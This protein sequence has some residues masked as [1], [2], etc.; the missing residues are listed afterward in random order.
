MRSGDF[1]P[2]LKEWMRQ[3]G[4]GS[5]SKFASWFMGIL[6]DRNHRLSEACLRFARLMREY[7]WLEVHGA[8]PGRLRGKRVFERPDAGRFY[9]IFRRAVV[10]RIDRYWREFSKG[11]VVRS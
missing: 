7:S 4:D 9:G 10:S 6:V 8:I 3:L 11:A 2:I 1:R 5:G